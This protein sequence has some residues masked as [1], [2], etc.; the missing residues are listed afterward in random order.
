MLG[1][2][3]AMCQSA[4]KEP[5]DLDV[6][7]SHISDRTYHRLSCCATKGMDR[8]S[9]SSDFA[10]NKWEASEE[11]PR[12]RNDQHMNIS[13]HFEWANPRLNEHVADRDIKNVTDWRSEI[14]K[15]RVT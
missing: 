3:H 10:L 8:P 13:V 14:I 1:E 9:L 5:T 15:C 12:L 6:T 2:R 7:G 4:F 11:L